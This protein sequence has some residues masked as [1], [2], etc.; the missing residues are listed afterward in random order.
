MSTAKIAPVV[1]LQKFRDS[2]KTAARRRLR[3]RPAH[4]SNPFFADPD[5]SVKMVKPSGSK[6]LNLLQKEKGYDH[7]KDKQKRLRKQAEK[8]K[9]QKTQEED[10]SASE[11]DHADGGVAVNGS[12]H[13]D[14]SSGADEAEK[15]IRAEARK[16]SAEK[17]TSEDEEDSD[18]EET[19]KVPFASVPFFLAHC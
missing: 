4:P 13:E 3:N 10:D 5:R 11:E 2:R 12:A 7:K 1:A 8:R 19:S 9:Q 18:D 15:Q 14:S 16:A 17:H 6:L